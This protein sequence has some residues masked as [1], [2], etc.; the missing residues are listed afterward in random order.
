MGLDKKSWPNG[1][2]FMTFFNQIPIQVPNVKI[3]VKMEYDFPF[4]Y[5]SLG[6]FSIEICFPNKRIPSNSF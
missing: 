5:G 3:F 6:L 2:L 1:L 4:L